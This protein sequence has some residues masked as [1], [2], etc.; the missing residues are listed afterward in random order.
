MSFVFSEPSLL[1]VTW[2]KD[3]HSD[4]RGRDDDEAQKYVVHGEVEA[5]PN[6]VLG[7]RVK[8]GSVAP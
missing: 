1:K 6:V 3:E 2:G 7:G 5:V 4:S 8:V